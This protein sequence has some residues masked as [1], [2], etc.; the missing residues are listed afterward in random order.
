MGLT[1]LPTGSVVPG[2]DIWDD[3]DDWV[4]EPLQLV[5][6]SDRVESDDDDGDDPTWEHEAHV[7][8]HADDPG[9]HD[10]SDGVEVDDDDD[11]EA[12]GSKLQR[13]SRTSVVGASL[14]G[15]GIGLQQVINPRD[16]IQIEIE[17]DDDEDDHLDPVKVKLDK[18]RP[19]RSVAILRPWLQDRRHPSARDDFDD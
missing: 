14:A 6:S 17:A 13:W 10:G 18:E 8:V 9:R 12:F 3:D 15:M 2:A 1:S 5:H 4:P 16:P 11:H 7:A 19:E